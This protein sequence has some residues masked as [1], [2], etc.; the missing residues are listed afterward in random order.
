MMKMG[1]KSGVYARRPDFT[2]ACRCGEG[3]RGSAT[4]STRF[5]VDLAR[6][7]RLPHPDGM[8]VRENAEPI[9]TIS[10]DPCPDKILIKM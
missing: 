10:D 4:T 9:R 3:W 1:C 2:L 5:A 8:E 6:P 7:V